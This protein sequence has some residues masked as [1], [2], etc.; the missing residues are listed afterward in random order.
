M[1]WWCGGVVVG[2][3]VNHITTAACAALNDEYMGED[4]VERTQMLCKEGS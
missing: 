3:V 2:G 4:R 1:V